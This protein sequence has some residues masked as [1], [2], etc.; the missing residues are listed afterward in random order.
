VGKAAKPATSCRD[1]ASKHDQLGH[2]QRANDERHAESK[3]LANQKAA[4][5]DLKCTG[6]LSLEKAIEDHKQIE[7]NDRPLRDVLKQPESYDLKSSWARRR[8]ASRKM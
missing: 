6:A 8:A 2:P 3:H 1:V 4:P 5:A 7:G